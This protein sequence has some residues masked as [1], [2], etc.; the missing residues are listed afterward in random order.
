[1]L[2]WMIVKIT[3]N[4]SCKREINN[5]VRVTEM[6]NDLLGCLIGVVVGVIFWGLVFLICIRSEGD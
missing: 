2:S 6:D 4:R 1:M 3:E 5:K